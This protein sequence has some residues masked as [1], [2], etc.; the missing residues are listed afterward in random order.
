LCDISF[1]K[2]KQEARSDQ[3]LY[4]GSPKIKKEVYYMGSPETQEISVNP[5]LYV[6]KGDLQVRL[7]QQQCFEVLCWVIEEVKPILRYFSLRTF[8]ETY[9]D[10]NYM[11]IAGE[12]PQGINWRTKCLVVD[13][14]FPRQEGTNSE[15]DR[16]FILTRNGG[17]YFL[18]LTLFGF[19]KIIALTKESFAQEVSF[20]EMFLYKTTVNL[21]RYLGSNARILRH[22]AEEQDRSANLLYNMSK[23]LTLT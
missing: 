12:L 7:N 5:V 17:T 3:Q 19:Y 22:R 1:R 13:V 4:I 20:P 18:E 8:E 14:D 10:N 9:K 6:L 21:M 11:V 2:K 23:R 15:S 16:F